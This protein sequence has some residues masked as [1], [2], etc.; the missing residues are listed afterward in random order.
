MAPNTT[1]PVDQL[2]KLLQVH[3]TGHFSQQADHRAARKSVSDHL[4]IWVIGGKG[5]IKTQGVRIEVSSGHLATFIPGIAHAYGSDEQQPWEILWVHFGGQLADQYSRAIRQY[6][7][8][9]AFLGLDTVLRDQFDDL[10][11]ASMGLP[12]AH[13]DIPQNQDILAGQMLAALLGRIIHI[14]KHRTQTPKGSQPDQ[15]NITEL[16]RYI[17]KNLTDNLTLENLAE[18]NHLSV[19][20]FSRLFRQ[21]FDT[22]PMH[23]II[24]QRMARAATLL[25]ETEAPIK[26]IGD[27]VGYEDAYY[28]SRLFKRITGTTPSDFRLKHRLST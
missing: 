6:G 9:M 16:R 26:Q 11:A 14:L 8:P 23:Y 27:A 18:Q 15:L 21:H 28:F 24:Q 4:L 13:I 22:S 3:S 20:H 25:T 17:H 1:N 7:N 5:F 10:M 19:T 2:E 12:H